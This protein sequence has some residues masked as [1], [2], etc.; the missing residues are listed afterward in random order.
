MWT[1]PNNSG[2]YIGIT[3]VGS[4]S[5]LQFAY[6]SSG[7]PAKVRLPTQSGQYELSIL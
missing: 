3:R 4:T 5:S 7:T 1:G 2:D 6:T